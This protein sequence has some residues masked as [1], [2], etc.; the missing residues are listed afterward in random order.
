[1]TIRREIL[2]REIT[3]LRGR[4]DRTTDVAAEV[5]AAMSVLG[6]LTDAVADSPTGTLAREIFD[7]ANARLFLHFQ[8]KQVKRRVLNKIVGGMVTFGGAPPPIEIY[9]G[10]TGRKEIKCSAAQRE[11]DP[12]KRESPETPE[13]VSSGEEGMSLGN[14]SRG[15]QT[16]LELFG[17]L[18]DDWDSSATSA[19]TSI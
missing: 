14:V 4:S 7:L 11:T 17:T 10:S 18:A 16:R 12:A 9:K 13:C 6:G 2:E 15:N 19:L 1:L 8:P 3:E 5:N